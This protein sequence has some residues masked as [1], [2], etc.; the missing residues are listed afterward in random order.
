MNKIVKEKGK[1]SLETTLIFNFEQT[2]LTWWSSIFFNFEYFRNNMLV[3]ENFLKNRF[4]NRYKNNIFCIR[5][6]EA[7]W[8]FLFCKLFILY[9]RLLPQKVVL[10]NNTRW[11]IP[12]F[13][14]HF[15]QNSW[16]IVVIVNC[17]SPIDWNVTFWYLCFRY[18]MVLVGL[19]LWAFSW[20]FTH[21][22]TAAIHYQSY[23]PVFL[24]RYV[25]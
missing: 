13:R 19:S 4:Q 12:S 1:L 17:K 7:F 8:Y 15:N 24:Q 21:V 9:N 11:K 5:V 25:C 16:S 20:I 23:N 22:K 14:L 3:I 18:V 6:F 10:R 2:E